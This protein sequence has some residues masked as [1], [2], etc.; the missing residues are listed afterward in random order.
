MA[1]LECLQ[2]RGGVLG[3]SD[4]YSQ[5]AHGRIQHSRCAAADAHDVLREGEREHG[6]R[7][8]IVRLRMAE[9]AGK[10]E[11]QLL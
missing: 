2:V 1:V 3:L 10:R 9:A 11:A 5:K 6:G 7:M 8:V 4:D